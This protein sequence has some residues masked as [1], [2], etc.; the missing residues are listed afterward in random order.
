M[1]TRADHL[2]ADCKKQGISATSLMVYE[3]KKN[4]CFSWWFYPLRDSA[5]EFM[6]RDNGRLSLNPGQY[7]IYKL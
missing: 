1:G 6:R 4:P 5:V 3:T 7:I 2:T